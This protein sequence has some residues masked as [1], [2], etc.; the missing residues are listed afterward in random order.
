MIG[1]EIDDL[2]QCKSFVHVCILIFEFDVSLYA[3][4]I[5]PSQCSEALG[6]VFLQNSLLHDNLLWDK[7]KSGHFKQLLH[8]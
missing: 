3:K 8:I 5:A 2:K 7:L 1:A 4:D 6:I